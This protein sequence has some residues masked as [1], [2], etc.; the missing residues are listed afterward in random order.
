MLSR[1]LGRLLKGV[2]AG[3]NHLAWNNK[4]THHVPATISLSS[5]AFQPNG[6]IPLQYA[7]PGVGDNISPALS[8]SDTPENTKELVIILQDPDAPLTKPFVHLIA[9]GISAHTDKFEDGE[10]ATTSTQIKFGKNTFKGFGYT[11]PRALPSHGPH[12]YVF[13]I[14]ALDKPLS[15]ATMPTLEILLDAM[16]NSVIARGRLDGFFESI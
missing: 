7:G 14:F 5:N 9:Y 1:I 16:Q 10:L 11:G 15:F 8:W 12:R 3:E 2:H 13:Q 6:N 4:A